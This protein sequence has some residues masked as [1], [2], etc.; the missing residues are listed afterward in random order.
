[1]CTPQIELYICNGLICARQ[2]MSFSREVKQPLETPGLQTWAC[3]MSKPE[4]HTWEGN[5][6]RNK[7]N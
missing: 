2:G 3:K 4:Q 7:Q 5:T 6:K 1:M